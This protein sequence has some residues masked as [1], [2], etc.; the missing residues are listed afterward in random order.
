MKVL[1]KYLLR[2]FLKALLFV[3]IAFIF[4]F[5]VVD[6]FD[7][8]SKFIEK[9]V[10]ILDILLFYLYQTPSIAVLVFPVG[11]LL[12]LFFSLGMMAKHFEILALKA[13]GISLYR[14]F[15]TYL[16]AGFIMSFGVILINELVVPF[17]NEQMKTHKRTKI[18]KL[19]PIDYQMQNNLKYLG[20]NG[21]TYSIRTYDGKKQVIKEVTVLKFNEEYKIE[22]RID[23]ARAVWQ[24]S[25]WQFQDGYIRYFSDSLEQRVDHFSARDFPEL[26]E[27]PDDFSRRVKSIDEMNYAELRNYLQKMRRTGKDPSKALVELYTK[28]SFPFATVIIILLGAPLSAD[29]RRSGLA[30][31]FGLSL[32]VSFIYWG[33]LQVS[34]A[35]GI[36][37][38]VP[39]LLS[40]WIPNIVFM[41]IGGFL[42][43]RIKK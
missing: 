34:K 16:I 31:G 25:L 12:S 9:R 11:V 20:E 14:I 23:A 6:L 19:P 28:I 5:I 3:L 10:A 30:L 41:V 42:M 7:D 22:S 18:N 26:A 38:N 15:A 13:N 8:L 27:K 24:D 33:V 37:G 21:Y 43:V 1:D 32:L 17:A 39:P 29:S 4:I 35:Y 40:A 2:E 36:N